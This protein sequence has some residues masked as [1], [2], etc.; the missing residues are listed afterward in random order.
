MPALPGNLREIDPTWVI[1]SVLH[2]DPPWFHT[3]VRRYTPVSK[4]AEVDHNQDL[5]AMEMG[6]ESEMDLVS[7]CQPHIER[8][9]GRGRVILRSGRRRRKS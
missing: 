7:L 8:G 9:N 2:V 4:E 6:K 1:P 5:R 3:P